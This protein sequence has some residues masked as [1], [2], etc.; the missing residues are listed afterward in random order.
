MEAG[1]KGLHEALKK[2]SGRMDGQENCQTQHEQVI[3]YLYQTIQAEGAEAIGRDEQLGQDVLDTKAQ[4][5]GQLQKH[6]RILNPM[7][8]ELMA[9]RAARE[10]QESHL[11]QLI[12]E[13]TSLIG[14]VKGKR[15]NPTP[16][17]SAGVGGGGGGRPP[18]TMHGAAGGTPD[19]GNSEGEGSDDQRRGRRDKR[20]DK[21]NKIPAAKEKAD[22]GKY[23]DA[24]EDELRFSR[25][26]GKT[27]GETMK[28]PA[29]PLS[30]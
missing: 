12:K 2:V 20:L 25:A 18:P 1:T 4:P 14:K 11:A 8:A 21:R 29:E 5:Q 16:E 19:P 23:G 26:L 3:S 30:E 13:V 7:M 17:Q 22:E 9:N 6:E 27:I 15:S 28:G 10:R 24:T